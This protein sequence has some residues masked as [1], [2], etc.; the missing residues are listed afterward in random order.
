M[1]SRYTHFPPRSTPDVIREIQR[2]LP[3]ELICIES[4]TPSH[5]RYYRPV[6]NPTFSDTRSQAVKETR[7]HL[8]VAVARTLIAEVPIGIL[9]SGGIG[10]YD[11]CCH[12]RTAIGEVHAITVGY[13]GHSPF[14][15]RQSA[16]KTAAK[17]GITLH[18]LELTDADFVEAFDEYTEYLDEPIGDPAAIMQWCI[19]RH[20]KKLGFK[21]LLSGLGGD[22]LFFGYDIANDSSESWQTIRDLM[23]T[24][25]LSRA[26][27]T[28]FLKHSIFKLP[29]LYRALRRFRDASK[30][31]SNGALSIT[32]I[33]FQSVLVCSSNTW[34]P[35][36]GYSGILQLFER[37]ITSL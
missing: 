9:L 37:H 6:R 10:L 8:E 23:L 2:V 36:I 29:Q 16:R 13:R 30:R 31:F 34:H 35:S 18:E 33:V 19:Y 28:K 26:T 17:L 32:D 3:G 7:Q 22:E 21:V 24:L 4:G 14:D 5:L 1:I 25:P 27:V 11:D 20:A 15:E 12:Q